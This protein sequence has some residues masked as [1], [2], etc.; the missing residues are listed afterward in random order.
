MENPV[1]SARRLALVLCC[2]LAAA[3][4]TSVQA[5]LTN[6]WSFNNA[7][8]NTVNAGTTMADSISGENATVR[9]N[10]SRFT[11][12]QLTLRGPSGGGN[13]INTTIGNTGSATISGYIDL[14]NGIISS[15]T[16]LTVEIWATPLGFRNWMRLMDFG[17]T[18]I[19]EINDA[20]TGPGNTTAEDSLRLS[21]AR[22]TSLNQQKM[23]IQTDA[24]TFA[25]YQSDLA[26]TAGTEYHY[27][28]T[29]QDGVGTYG[30][31]GGRVSWY[32]NGALIGSA[33]APFHLSALEDVNNWLGRSQFGADYNAYANY[34]ELRIYNHALTQAEISADYNAG[35]TTIPAAPAT[36]PTPDNLWTFTVQA[37]SAVASGKTFTDS[38]G[39]MIA[40]LRGNGGALSGSAVVLPG[41]TDGNQTAAGIS[42]YI[43]LPNG[44]LQSPSTQSVSFEAWATPVSSK[45]WQRLFDF[46]RCGTTHGMGAAT[47]EILD[48]STPPGAF[49]GYDNLSLTFNNAANINSQQ[50]EGQNDGGMAQ[51]SFSAATT[52]AGTKYHYVYVIENTGT[53]CQARWYRNGMWQNTANYTFHLSDIT[54]VNNWIGRSMYSGDSNS[55]LSLDELRIYRRV[56][57]PAE[58]LA[59]YGA[60]PD[61]STGPPEELPPVPVPENRWTFNGTAGNVA[62]G[63]TFTDSGTGAIATVR[64]G[65][66]TRTT[67]S[68][69]LTGSTAG[70]STAAAIAGYLD[71]PNG[72][73]SS[74]PSA[75]YEIWLTGISNKTWQR[76]FDFGRGNVTLNGPNAG[77]IIDGTIAPGG[78]QSYDGVML[79]LNNNGVQG[80]HRLEAML[81]NASVTTVNTDLS[82]STTLGTQYHFAMVVEDGAGAGGASGCQVRWYR[83]GILQGSMDLAYRMPAI[84]DVN[85]WIGRSA[86]SADSNSNISINELRVHR[87]A[88]TTKELLASVAAGP[89][90]TFAAPVAADDSATIQANQ[91]VLVDVLANDTGSP[92]PST[93][94][95]IS[96]PAI[97]T[98]SVSN[99][100]IF[101][102]HSGSSAAPVTFTYR[103]GS[104]SGTADATVTINFANSLRLTNTALAMPAA[105][106]ATAWQLADALPGLTF[107]RPI[108]LASL[109]ADT[110]QLYVCEQ[111]GVIKRVADVS[112]LTPSTT[113]F[114]DLTTLGAG[115]DIGPLLAGQ[116]ENGLLGL[117]FHPNYATN[118][119]FYVAYTF[120]NRFHDW[121]YVT[122]SVR[123]Y[124][125]Y[126]GR[127]QGGGGHEKPWNYYLTLIFWRREGFLWTQ[128]LIGGLAIVGMLNAFLDRRRADHK[129]AILV[130]LSTYAIVLLIIYSVIPYK[131]PWSVMGVVY[132]FALLAG[133]GARTIFR[134]FTD[135][136]VMT[137]RAR[138]GSR[139][140]H[141]QPVPPDKLRDRLQLSGGDTL[142]GERV[143]Q[144]LRL[145]SHGA[146]PGDSLVAHP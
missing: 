77:E 60:G 84:S 141:L 28:L 74:R 128:A 76:I 73:V 146:E 127:S 51:A 83:N 103:V 111:G 123:T 145:L 21:F 81:A 13:A 10:Y 129:R 106:P 118:G 132:A 82:A 80:S 139:R 54:D 104:I 25:F 92:I 100:K 130:A 53:G 40:T 126:L 62:S 69:V 97:G 38:I 9:G 17:K 120:S 2:T 26:T 137:V 101:Y 94:Q 124:E 75:T 93:L 22:E 142:R 20:T 43:D 3:F 119:F 88:V 68:L 14:P 140:R 143:A 125:S 63:T 55:N 98:A 61:P 71:L 138:D 59:S 7:Q 44:A 4:A 8:T 87:R 133:L 66:S 37:D 122:E 11:G 91:K 113:V 5:A 57:T 24:A 30:A 45:N 78:T 49:A 12:T 34:N 112:S 107:T 27:V 19:G 32:R 79:S 46:G 115:F 16:N 131:T 36:P 6:R 67:T 109:P 117:A 70:N 105:P 89:D 85:N 72:F 15:K 35:P 18:N 41:T 50:L 1:F 86:W 64:G 110:K 23:Q 47:G 31:S 48:D 52:V 56:I 114:L 33:D 121:Q 95:I 96:A 102:A 144:S 42:A 136:P 108:C 99:G 65:G 90:A 39:G 135:V 134:V 29:F 58:I 116:P